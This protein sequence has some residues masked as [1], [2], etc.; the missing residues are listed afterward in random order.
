[1]SKV[2]EDVMCVLFIGKKMSTGMLIKISFLV[3]IFVHS[4]YP[5]F[6]CVSTTVQIFTLCR[7]ASL[8]SLLSSSSCCRCVMVTS[9]LLASIC[10]V[11]Q[12]EHSPTILH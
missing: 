7:I 8:F 5:A 1:M 10:T 6:Y 4:D 11:R 9:L 2:T 12:H 3:D